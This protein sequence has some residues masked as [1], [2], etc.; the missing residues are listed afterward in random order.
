MH[1]LI[2]IPIKCKMERAEGAG[3]VKLGEVDLI[4]EAGG[5]PVAL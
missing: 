5:A 4:G 1:R 3:V 2:A